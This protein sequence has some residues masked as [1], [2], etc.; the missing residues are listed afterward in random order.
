MIVVALRISLSDRRRC[1][2]VFER[3]IGSS[4]AHT[5]K[6]RL[7]TTR[8]FLKGKTCFDLEEMRKMRP[9]GVGGDKYCVKLR[10]AGGKSESQ[11]KLEQQVLA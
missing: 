3:Y 1:C 6:A 5:G 7:C 9:L 2:S 11:H 4:Q 8:D 10:Q